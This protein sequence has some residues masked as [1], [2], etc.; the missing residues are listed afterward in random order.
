MMPAERMENLVE[1]LG[2]VRGE[3]AANVP[4]ARFTWFKTGGPADVLFRPADLDDLVAFLPRIPPGV[5]MTVIGNASNLLVRDGGI[6]GVV[7]RLGRA[8][9]EIDLDGADVVAG[10]AAADLNIARQARDAGIAGLEFL[11]GVPGAIGGAVAMNAGAYGC[12]VADVFVSATVVGRDGTVSAVEREAMDFAYRHSSLGDNRIVTAVRLR[13]TAGDKDEIAARMDD[14]QREREAGQPLRTLTGGSTF[15]NPDGHKAWQLID[16]AGCRGLRRGAAVVSE[17][18]C[19]FLVNEGG[20]SAADIEGLGE[21]VRRR[22]EAQSGIVLEWEIRRIGRLPAGE[23]N[24]VR[25]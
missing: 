12:E 18:H 5:P 7:I 16:A 24:E 2:P 10:G 4:L 1:R 19:N 3:L 14:I 6:D 23:L 8:F 25:Q 21:E 22:V 11:A 15:K 9:T 17:K 20:A 13:G